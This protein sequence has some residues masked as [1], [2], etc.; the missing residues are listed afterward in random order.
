M[1][2]IK[3]FKCDNISFETFLDF[4]KDEYHL[5]VDCLINGKV[6]HTYNVYSSS[7]K[8]LMLKFVE[9]DITRKDIRVIENERRR[10]GNNVI[11]LEASDTR[12]P[13][14]PCLYCVQFVPFL[15]KKSNDFVTL[16]AYCIINFHVWKEYTLHSFDSMKDM[17]KFLGEK[18]S[19]E[20]LKLNNKTYNKI[21]I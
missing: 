5:T 19:K 3:E 9:G 17:L 2:T 7:Y 4:S 12:E 1:D 20:D 6:L 21:A 10:K 18:P 14:K 11:S 13:V 8:D 16:K 15:E